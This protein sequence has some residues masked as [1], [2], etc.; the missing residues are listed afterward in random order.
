M[1][2]TNIYTSNMKKHCVFTFLLQ[3]NEDDDLL[4]TQLNV[5]VVGIAF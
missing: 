3:K 5:Q 2:S 4:C 1:K